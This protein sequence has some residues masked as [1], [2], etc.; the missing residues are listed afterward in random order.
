MILEKSITSRLQENDH[1]ARAVVIHG[2][3]V[4]EMVPVSRGEV[5]MAAR[6]KVIG[7]KTVKKDDTL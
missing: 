1:H 6:E 5:S 4:T 2:K 3:K 7:E